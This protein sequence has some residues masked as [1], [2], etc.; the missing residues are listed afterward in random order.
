MNAFLPVMLANGM[1][2]IWVSM[3][4]SAIAIGSGILG[5]LVLIL[6][7]VKPPGKRPRR[8][9]LASLV[10]SFTPFVVL[11]A[12]AGPVSD[13][14]SD[15]ARFAFPLSFLPIVF[16]GLAVWLTRRQAPPASRQ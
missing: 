16:S 10:V 3:L 9:A 6:G 4:W 12:Y 11:L 8:V 5:L 7:L 15:F 1:I 13:Y 2:M 14:G